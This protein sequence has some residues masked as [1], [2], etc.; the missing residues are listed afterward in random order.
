MAAIAE[1]TTTD[2]ETVEN[3]L[4]SCAQFYAAPERFRTLK[5]FD[6]DSGNFLLVD[7][8]WDGF[9]RIHRT[10]VHIEVRD[11]KFWIQKDGTQD[12][13]TLNLLAAGIPND[14]IVLG[15]QHPAMRKYTDFAA[16]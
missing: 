14:R 5:I 3:A 8:G 15:F 16:E 6:R 1:V 10:W 11:G 13:I 12:G 7:E 9:D 4:R 2:F